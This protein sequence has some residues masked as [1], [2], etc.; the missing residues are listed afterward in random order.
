M[1]DCRGGGGRTD[2]RLQPGARRPAR[3]GRRRSAP[4]P[5]D[6]PSR[7]RRGHRHSRRRC[8]AGARLRSAGERAGAIAAAARLEM[9]RVL[10]DAIGTRGM[11][12]GQAIDLEAVKQPLDEAALERMHR[13]KTG[14]LI[15]ASVLLGAISAGVAAMLRSAP[16]SRNSARRSGSRSRSRTT[17]STSKAPPRRSANAPARTPIASSRPILP[18]SAWTR[19][20]RGRSR[21]PRS[22]H[23]RARAAGRRV[24]RTCANSRIFSWR[25]S[26]ERFGSPDTRRV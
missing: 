18:C 23:C 12:G 6:L 10:A 22:R 24:S 17:S 16:R 3:H 14:A 1:L 19:H 5:P 9:L 26:A 2:P 7:L 20:A 4:R 21:A 8:I 11:A 15:Q 25:A 13:Q